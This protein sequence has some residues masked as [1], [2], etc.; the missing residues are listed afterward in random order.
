MKRIV[1]DGAVRK[2]ELLE[3]A[4]ELFQQHGYEKTS[5]NTI[6]ERAG[7]SKGAF[8][9]HFESKEEVLDA[10]VQQQVERVLNIAREVV[11]SKDLGALEKMRYLFARIQHYRV[12]HRERLF[13]IFRFYLH[14]NN[15]LYRYKLEEYTIERTLPMYVSMIEQ[16]IGE[17]VFHTSSAEQAA[18]LILRVAPLYRMKMARCYEARARDP[19]YQEK[20]GEIALFLEETVTRVLGMREGTLNIA[21]SFIQFFS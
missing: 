11:Y 8:Y 21:G 7:V 1:K 15:V 2:R 5:V 19:G 13:S 4:F 9:H 6:I 17:G 14:E 10:I 3:I 20:I 12:R 16:G 18:E